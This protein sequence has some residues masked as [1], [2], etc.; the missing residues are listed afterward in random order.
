MK[1]CS[2]CNNTLPLDAFN[3]QTSGHLG[4]RSECKPCVKRYVQTKHG[5][6]LRIHTQQCEASKVR[7]YNLPS[8]TSEQ[9]ETW[10]IFNAEFND[11]YATW[12]NSNY[13]KNLRPSVDRINDYK[14]YTLNNIQLITW[15]QNNQ[16][17]YESRMDGSNNKQSLAVDMLDGEGNF[18]ERFYSVSEAARRF[19]GIPSN[20]IGAATNR[21]TR[22]K[23]SDGTYRQK[24][25]SFAYGYKWRYSSVPNNN[26]EIT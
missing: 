14:S 12:V 5:L 8:Y 3:N 21:I 16:K 23:Q 22:V 7:G 9:L 1:T 19:N 2:H 10:L 20:I 18:I 15:E 6:A 26:S 17:N 4:K 25:A 24:T 13:A 11:L